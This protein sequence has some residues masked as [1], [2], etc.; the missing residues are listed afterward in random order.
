MAR[1][2]GWTKAWPAGAAVHDLWCVTNGSSWLQRRKLDL[3][4]LQRSFDEVVVSGEVG[5]QKSDAAFAAQVEER[6][7]RSGSEPVVVVG[8]SDASD[9][10]L[11][12][13]LGVR[14]VRVQPGR[15]PGWN[16]TSTVA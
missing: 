2:G 12:W 8:D 11:A 10:A 16:S 5:V 3:A 6:L 4:G 14:H 7:A 13:F 9:G 15:S 1:S